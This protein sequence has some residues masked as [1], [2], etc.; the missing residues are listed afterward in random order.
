VSLDD[1][2][3][4]QISIRPRAIDDIERCADYLEEKSTPETAKRFRSA[5]MQ[6]VVQIETV[7]GAGSPR[8]LR[9]PRLSGLRMWIVPGFRN[10]LLFYLTPNGGAEIIRLLHGA[11]DV[12][13]ILEAEE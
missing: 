11:Q 7:P 2:Q 9:N 3:K 10:Y 4:R 13:S 12:N 1:T 8:R 5:I 6:A